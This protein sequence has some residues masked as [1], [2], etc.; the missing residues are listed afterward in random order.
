MLNVYTAKNWSQ[1]EYV[2]KYSSIFYKTFSYTNSN[3]ILNCIKVELRT[4]MDTI[5][6]EQLIKIRPGS[7]WWMTSKIRKMIKKR[8]RLKAV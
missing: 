4:V 5:A 3:D 2:I 1:G 7:Q 6:P 8:N